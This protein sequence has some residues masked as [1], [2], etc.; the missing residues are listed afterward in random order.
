MNQQKNTYKQKY[1]I[2]QKNQ[3]Q[4]ADFITL[5]NFFQQ[6]QQLDIEQ[7]F[8]LWKQTHKFISIKNLPQQQ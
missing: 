8:E 3:Q 7:S 2:N 5:Y 4:K 6:N 1:Y